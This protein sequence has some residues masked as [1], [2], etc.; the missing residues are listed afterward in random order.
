MEI[1]FSTSK[2]K[3]L[4]PQREPFLFVDEVY[5]IDESKITSGLNLSGDEDFFKGHFPGMPVMPGVLL[6]EALFQSAAILLSSGNSS[7]IGVVT[8]VSNAK[9]K[10]VVR[11]NSKLLMEVELV[12]RLANASFLKGKTMVDG[13]TVLVLEFAVALIDEV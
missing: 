8:R 4:I 10:S 7:K 1:L 2:I 3:E 6:Q 5:S 12:E 11:P 9:F 13:K